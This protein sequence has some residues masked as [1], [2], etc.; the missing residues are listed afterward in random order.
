MK[1]LG[2]DARA[3]IELAGGGEGPSAEDRVRVRRA[4]MA[5]VSTGVGAGSLTAAA[6]A[7]AAAKGAGLMAANQGAAAS[8]AIGLFGGSTAKVSAWLLVGGAIG[9]GVAVPVMQH[10]DPA[11]SVASTDVKD[12]AQVNRPVRPQTEAPATHRHSES[13]STSP[14]KAVA[15]QPPHEPERAARATAVHD[16]SKRKTPSPATA[17]AGPAD[18]LS[19]ESALLARA[20]R[21]LA[22]GNPAQAL[23]TLD[24]H[25][26]RHPSG[27]LS[28]ER[29]AAR[30]IALCSAGHK[31][32]A[33]GLA[34][35]FLAT[36]PN[37]PL[38]PRVRA[39][40]TE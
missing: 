32:Q 21:D 39:A 31:A 3:L 12:P 26:R 6:G 25:A 33:R 16:A 15:A 19:A 24:V 1:D 40:C 2:P 18:S 37:S 14:T 4:V 28:P 29:D 17:G 9:L 27:A 34:A 10:Q 38:S 36:H 23:A 13:T 8:T 30:V 7:K 22:S 5:A 35:T 20:Q 11:A